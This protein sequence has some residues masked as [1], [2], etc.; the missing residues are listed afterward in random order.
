[1]QKAPVIGKGKDAPFTLKSIRDSIPAHCFE[2]SITTSS[3]YV[4]RDITF[5]CVLWYL[6]ITYLHLMPF[7]PLC[8]LFFALVQGTILTGLWVLAHEAGHSALYPTETLN[9]V[10]GTILHSILLVPFYSWRFSHAAHH[11]A[12]NHLSKDTVFV[13]DV[14]QHDDMNDIPVIQLFKFI[15]MIVLGWPAYLFANISNADTNGRFNSHFLPRSPDLFNDKQRKWVSISNWALITTMLIFAEFIRR[16][17]ALSF[18]QLYLGPYLVVNHWLIMYTFL[19][20]THKEVAHYDDQSWSYLRGALATVDRDYGIFDF[21]HHRI[22]STHVAHHMFSRIPH[23]HALEATNA[24]KPVLGKYYLRDDT[25]VFT[26]YWQ[27]FRDC[28]KVV[29]AYGHYYFESTKSK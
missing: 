21:F 26:A 27:T 25:P 20:H 2:R 23:Y 24:I 9:G 13:P 29:S 16:Y 6:A 28:Q 1:M 3:L 17:G 11:G 19:Q 5:A 12:T 7:Q 8:W 10:V 14:N 22:G 4:L 15:R 18:V